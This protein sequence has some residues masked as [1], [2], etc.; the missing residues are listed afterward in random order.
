MARIRSHLLLIGMLLLLAACT[1]TLRYYSLPPVDVAGLAPVG[2]LK[3]I[4][5]VGPV[6]LAEQIDQPQLVIRRSPTQVEFKERD[7][8]AGPLREAV[9]QQ[10]IDTLAILL[11]NKRVVP[12]PWSGAEVP[13]YRIAVEVMDMTATPGGQARLSLAWSVY[14]RHGDKPIKVQTSE[15]QQPVPEDADLNAMVAI[16]QVLLQRAIQDMAHY[17]AQFGVR[18]RA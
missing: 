15:Y 11:D 2:H 12:F 16:Y 4:L 9:R 18:L 8:W 5:A 14:R 1:S 6:T 3:G 10:M 13:R 17:L 7:L